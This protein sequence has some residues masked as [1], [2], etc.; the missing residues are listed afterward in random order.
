MPA[1]LPVIKHRN[2]ETSIPPTEWG[3]VLLPGNYRQFFHV[4]LTHVKGTSLSK[5]LESLDLSNGLYNR[6]NNGVD[7]LFGV[8]SSDPNSN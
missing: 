1:T 4:I 5:G 2:K 8:K 7:F 6:I 3:A